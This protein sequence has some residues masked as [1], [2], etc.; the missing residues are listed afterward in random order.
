VVIEDLDRAL[1]SMLRDRVSPD[2]DIRFESPS[3]SFPDRESTAG[4]L[5][6]FFLYDIREDT[7]DTVVDGWFVRDSG[8][9]AIGWQAPFRYFRCSFAVSAWPRAPHTEHGLLGAILKECAANQTLPEQYL[10]GE[11]AD[12]KLA[13]VLSGAAADQLASAS[14]LRGTLDI[15]ARTYLDVTAIIAFVPPLRTELAASASSID[16]GVSKEDGGIPDL[17]PEVPSR[18]R[19]TRRIAE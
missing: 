16:L 4:S 11:L 18:P 19:P 8:G 5:I 13:V 17:N 12:S 10:V 15:P 2:L 3:L 1:A 7:R 14:S 9:A 6:N